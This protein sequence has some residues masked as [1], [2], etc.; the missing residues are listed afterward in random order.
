V[1]AGTWA[2]LPALRGGWIWDDTVAIVQNAALRDPAGLGKIWFSPAGPDYFPLTSTVQWIQWQ[3]W[4]D[5]TLGY[6]LTNLALHLIG[7]LLLGRIVTRLGARSGWVAG[8]IFA[9]HPMTVESV[10]WISELKNVLSLPPLL[11]A[12]GAYV[13]FDERKRAGD[14][15]R[16]LV[17]F[18]AALLCKPSVVMLPAV[19]LLYGLWRRGRL[20][21]RD[22]LSSAP[23]FALSLGLGLVA[24]WF[25]EHRAAGAIALTLAP[26]SARF[27]GAAEA[28]V[29]YFSQS[30]WPRGL[31]LMYPFSLTAARWMPAVI[32]AAALAAVCV[33]RRD[34]RRQVWFGL[35]WFVLNLLPVLGFLPMVYL[36]IAPVADHLAYLPLAGICGLVGCM[37]W[38][39][40]SE[41]AP[42]TLLS[43]AAAAVVGIF[44]VQS[45]AYAAQ[46]R[47]ERTLWTYTLEHNPA[48]WQ[49]DLNLGCI[50]LDEGRNEEAIQHFERAIRVHPGY[51]EAYN[52]LGNAL[53]AE[54]RYP[55]AIASFRDAIRSDPA[56]PE[57]HY[58]LGNALAAEGRQNAA[59]LSYQEA[60]R[61]HPQ[62]AEA[63]NSLATALAK[64][65]H[66][67]A[68]VSHF[69]AALRLNSHYEQARGNL[70]IVQSA[71]ARGMIDK[72]P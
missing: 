12:F 40:I 21:R 4:G 32:A 42:P 14:L 10:A 69:Q 11:L 35:G 8:L 23:F 54:H 48:A 17:W 2:A 43:L 18:F 1:L 26:W 36:R 71:I 61:L 62:F 59:I 6:H 51:A 15:A 58:D 72:D 46:F 28:V 63:E 22:W 37:R 41:R 27:G 24:I 16:S 49:A 19:I 38:S 47:D 9:V 53:A 33:K 25:Q 64:T 5:R 39:A 60:L 66:L 65:G 56:I 52:D 55:D 68:A 20:G 70:A 50:L 34:W 44:A 3:L 57:V 7:A 45:H 29:F 30:V 31:L 67:R 13:D